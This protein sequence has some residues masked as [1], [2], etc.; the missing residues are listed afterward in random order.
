[1]RRAGV[2]LVRIDGRPPLDTAPDFAAAWSRRERSS[3]AAV[4]VDT[5]PKIGESGLVAEVR[6]AQIVEPGVRSHDAG[7]ADDRSRRTPDRR[8]RLASRGRGRAGRPIHPPFG[9]P[10]I[11]HGGRSNRSRPV[12]RARARSGAEAF[13]FDGLCARVGVDLTVV[14]DLGFGVMLTREKTAPGE[15]ADCRRSADGA[16]TP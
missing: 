6:V 14:V 3:R 2:Q 12:V 9:V 4:R 16:L 13:A 5:L 11:E 1:M 10:G 8:V 15:D 7:R